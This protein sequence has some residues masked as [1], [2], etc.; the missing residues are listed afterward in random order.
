V[1]QTSQDFSPAAINF[2]R[3]QSTQVPSD[4]FIFP[5]AHVAAADVDSSSEQ[6]SVDFVAMK[7]HETALHISIF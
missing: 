3:E 4:D 2:P 1:G 7:A 5:A 6:K